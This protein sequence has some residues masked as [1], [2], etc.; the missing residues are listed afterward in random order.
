MRDATKTINQI[1]SYF[2]ADKSSEET[3]EAC[4]LMRAAPELLAACE[5]HA[6][7]AATEVFVGEPT[8]EQLGRYFFMMV[9][10]LDAIAKAKGT[11][12]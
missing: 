7:F 11:Q 5:A 4:R 10:S 1:L 9:A 8:T 2:H 6:E 3:Q 12:P